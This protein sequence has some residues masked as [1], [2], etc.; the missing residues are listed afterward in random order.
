MCYDAISGE[1]M[2]KE[3]VEA[4]RMAELETFR[5]RGVYEIVPIEE[6]W[7]NVGEGPVGVKWV[8]TNK[9]DEQ[10]PEYLGRLVA[11]EIEKDKGEDLFAATPP[12]EAKKMLVSF[13]ASIPGMLVDFGDV[14]R[15]YFHTRT[16]RRVYVELAK[17]DYEQGK[18]GL[19]K[20]AMYG[21]SGA[22]Q[23]WEMERT[24]M[25]V[26]AGFS[27]GL[28]STCVSYHRGKNRPIRF[29]PV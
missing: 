15:L 11:K 5:R 1:L 22:A 17:A 21:T 8:D 7:K 13:W 12:L 23:N 28:N 25:K 14:A 10:N 4:A 20:K 19:L 24:E 16:R 27:Q 9:G 18:H 3:L 26:Q 6:C 2:V 29:E